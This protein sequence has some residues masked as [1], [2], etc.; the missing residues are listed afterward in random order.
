MEKAF[1]KVPWKNL[2]N[3]LEG[4]G[5]DYRD[6]RIIYN[7]YKD[8]SPSI[9]STDKIETAIIRKDVRQGYLLLPTLFNIYVEQSI[10]E[11]RETF[12]RNKK[13]IK[14]G[15]EIISFLRFTEDI[16]LLANNEHDLE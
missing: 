15:K 1:D 10:K 13:G 11:I 14:V 7:L 8:Q 16:A 4:I 12:L 3:T 9:K 6:R 2:F 5:V